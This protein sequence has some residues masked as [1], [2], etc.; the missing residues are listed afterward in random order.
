MHDQLNPVANYH[1]TKCFPVICPD[2][3]ATGA[4]SGPCYCHKCGYAVMMLPS[5]N[6]G[7]VGNW[8]EATKEMSK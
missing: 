7:V 5:C 4:N 1:L 3:G 6:G 8:T 2:C